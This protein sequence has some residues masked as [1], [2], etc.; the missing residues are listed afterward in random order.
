M[1]SADEDLEQLDGAQHSMVQP[2][3]ETVGS[4]PSKL[5]PKIP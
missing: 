4:F 2:S 3:W 1:P 5:N